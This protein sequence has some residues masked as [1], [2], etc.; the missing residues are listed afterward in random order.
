MRKMTKRVNA[1]I[2]RIVKKHGLKKSIRLFGDL[3]EVGG[4]NFRRAMRRVHRIAK[5]KLNKK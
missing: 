2:S 4:N 5:K 1:E 3:L